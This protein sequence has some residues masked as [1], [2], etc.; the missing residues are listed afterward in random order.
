MSYKL[1]Y[2]IVGLPASGKTTLAQ[3]WL[4]HG[5]V[6]YICDDPNV[7][8]DV[9]TALEKYDKVA[10]CDPYLCYELNRKSLEEIAEYKGFD[11]KY[12]FFQND[13]STCHYNA[14]KRVGK[15]VTKF[16]DQ[17]SKEYTIPRGYTGRQVYNWGHS[18]EALLTQLIA[19]CA[20][21]LITENLE[22][23]VSYA[24]DRIEKV[25]TDTGIID[26][27]RQRMK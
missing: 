3:K 27:I 18:D 25:L 16:I 11:I 12:T 19:V 8:G 24:Y 14:S 10:I 7:I 6:D 26:E 20:V 1:I 22:Y 9:Y 2:A 17:L 4:N 15:D 21:E 13:K 5:K 23:S